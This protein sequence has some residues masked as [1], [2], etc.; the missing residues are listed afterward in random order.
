MCLARDLGCGL[1]SPVHSTAG[2]VTS[3]GRTRFLEQFPARYLRE[4]SSQTPR[5]PPGFGERSIF[6]S[7]RRSATGY[8]YVYGLMESQAYARQMQDEMIGNRDRTTRVPGLCHLPLS[9]LQSGESDPH[10]FH[11]GQALSR[12]GI[13][14]NLVAEPR[15]TFPFIAGESVR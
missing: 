9:W 13:P 1:F 7:Q 12:S 3:F 8:I 2:C 15:E 10:I 4:N 14:A 11:V 6:Y 5:S